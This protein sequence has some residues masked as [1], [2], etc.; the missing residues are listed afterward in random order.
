MGGLKRG[1]ENERGNGSAEEDPEVAR[2]RSGIEWTEKRRGE[3][4]L[5]DI[6]EEL[7]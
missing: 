4:E 3:R 2:M 7:R 5:R 1:G 6:Q